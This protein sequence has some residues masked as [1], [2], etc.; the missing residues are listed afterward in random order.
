M[1]LVLHYSGLE[2]PLD[3]PANR[4]F[5]YD[6]IVALLE[7][8]RTKGIE[9]ETINSVGL[10]EEELSEAYLNA[11]VPSV[12]KKYRIRRVFGSRRRSGWFFGRRVPGLLV[13]EGEDRYPTEVL[14]HEDQNGRIVTVRDYLE[15]L[16]GRHLPD[17]SLRGRQLE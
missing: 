2:T 17:D 8:L 3:V 16:L 11:I 10:S 15:S 13:Y 5:D 14:P 12:H 7:S 9:Y 6:K 1:K 4:G